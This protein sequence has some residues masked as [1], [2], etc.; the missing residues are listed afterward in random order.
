[1]DHQIIFDASSAYWSRDPS[2]YFYLKETVEYFYYRF[3]SRG[4]LYLSEV[5]DA[6]G[7]RWNPYDENKCWIDG[8]GYDIEASIAEISDNAFEVFIETKPI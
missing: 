4:Y 8:E 7:V 2:N 5:Y 3:H 1:M 6:L